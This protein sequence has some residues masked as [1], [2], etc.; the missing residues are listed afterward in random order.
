[1][2]EVRG[3]EGLASQSYF[4][5]FSRLEAAARRLRFTRHSPLPARPD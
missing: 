4:S 3:A 5:V 1:M 2:D